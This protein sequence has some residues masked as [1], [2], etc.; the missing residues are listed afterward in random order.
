M[1]VLLLSQTKDLESVIATAAK[2]CYSSA[3]IEDLYEMN[4]SDVSTFIKMLASMS[5]ESPLEHISFTFGIEGVSRSLLA[6]LTRHRIASYSVQSQRYVAIDTDGF[7]YVTP[8]E[9]AKCNDA[10]EV[11]EEAMLEASKSYHRIKRSLTRKYTGEGMDEKK[12]EKKAIENARAVLPNATATKIIVTMNA[13]SLISFFEKRL[14]NRA[15]EEIQEL[16]KEMFTIVNE[17]CPSTFVGALPSCC[18]G[19]CKEGKM[20]CGKPLHKADFIKGEAREKVGVT[21]G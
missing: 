21:L 2:L 7:E 9:I 3:S 19:K 8:V 15:Q 4:K 6:Q 20:C 13:R 10:F 12:A 11:F 17:L 16:A 18:Y 5:H 1:K 14:C